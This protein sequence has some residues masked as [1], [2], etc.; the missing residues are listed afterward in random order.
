MNEL[1]DLENMLSDSQSLL[2]QR[3]R[4]T[5]LPLYCKFLFPPC[6]N[7]RVDPALQLTH[8]QC[9]SLVEDV[10][11]TEVTLLMPYLAYLRDRVSNLIPNC[12]TLQEDDTEVCIVFND[13][14][15]EC[16]KRGLQPMHR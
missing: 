13:S 8:S 10:C 11:Q 12:G 16:H 9:I 7:G 5:G 4:S 1:Q 2:T 3:C 15:T 14:S 6:F